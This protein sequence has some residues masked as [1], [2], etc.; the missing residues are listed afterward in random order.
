MINL[1]FVSAAGFRLVGDDFPTAFTPQLW[2]NESIAILEEN[3]VMGNLVHRDFENVI[4]SFG[5]TVN[6]RKPGEFKSIRKDR[7][8]NV[9]VQANTATNVAV[10]LNQHIHTT[11]LIRDAD[12]SKSF[13]DLVVEY[14]RPAMLSVAR[15][16]D[17][18]ISAQV[19]QF[20]GN[21]A[22]Q[23]G[24]LT[25]S[26]A[27]DYLL[28]ARQ[29][30]NVNKAYV[31]DRNL[32]LGSV[33]ETT[34]LKDP[35]FTQA[36]LVGDDGSALRN[37]SLGRKFGFDIFMAQNQPYVGA[38]T[39]VSGAVNNAAGYAAGTTSLTVDGLSAAITVGT[40]VTIAGDG[41]PHRIVSTTGGA[42]PTAMVIT[43]ALKAAVVD[44][45]VIQF[46]SKGANTGAQAVGYSKYLTV[47][48]TPQVGMPVT[49]GVTAGA[50]AIY[51]IIDVVGG[52][53]LLDRPLEEAVADAAV[54]N[55]G[56]SGSYN[57]AFHKNAVALVNR[58]LALPMPGTG[59][60]A[61]A[62]QW[63]GLSMRVVMA[64]DPYAQGH[65][66]TVDAL[67]GVKVLDVLLGSVLLG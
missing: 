4:S 47:S 20:L 6:T 30:L 43:P 45:A 63:N 13:K 62:A 39:V 64:Y 3:M 34:M 18:I 21:S 46:S 41:A 53:I 7:T 48:G 44:N 28:D 60:R 56:P 5:D 10:V 59:A 11:F 55:Y 33:S 12:Q 36:Y 26:N 66:V 16:I 23:L 37:A 2:A 29:V 67:L 25:S 1:K 31:D 51:G 49:F 15:Q 58:P 50:G 52:T 32:V 40:W 38:Q 24:G 42:T 8:D 57:F 65:L 22:G 61:A 35:S 27:G 17:T 19:H 9:T 54:V 14:L